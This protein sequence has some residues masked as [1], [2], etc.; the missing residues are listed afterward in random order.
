MQIK[1][2]PALMPDH[3]HAI[4]DLL[5]KIVKDVGKVDG[6]ETE[7]SGV[8]SNIFIYPSGGFSETD[9]RIRLTGT[10]KE[11]PWEYPVEE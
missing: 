4:E 6:G 11:P 2:Q 1:I 7:M 5:G 10:E 3:R 9:L 8:E